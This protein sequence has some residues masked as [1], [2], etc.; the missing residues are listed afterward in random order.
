MRLSFRPLLLAA[1]LLAGC[2]NEQPQLCAGH[3][4]RPACSAR[5]I[6]AAPIPLNQIKGMDER[7]LAATFGTAQARPPR[8]RD[9]HAA[10]RIPTAAPCSST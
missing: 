4:A 7:Q 3:A 1:L 6:R 8:R 5:P 9:P 10:L 2:N